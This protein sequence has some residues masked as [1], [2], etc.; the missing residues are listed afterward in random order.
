MALELTLFR[1]AKSDWHLDVAGDDRRRPLS[2]RGR[3]AAATMGRFLATSGR[4]PDLVLTSPAVRAHDTLR[5]A[6]AA[7]SWRCAVAVRP[8]LYGSFPE[9]LGEIAEVDA[10]VRSLMV[11][12]HETALLPLAGFLSGTLGVRLP[13]AAMLRLAFPLEHWSSI[14]GASATITWLVTPR[15]LT[16]SARAPELAVA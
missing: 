9:V 10:A 4:V 11:V 12:G 5:R 2:K 14:E 8:K 16:G 7:G 15:L 3:A 6:M 1:H 13:T